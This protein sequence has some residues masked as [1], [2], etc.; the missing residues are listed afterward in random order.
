M[1][2]SI[3]KILDHFGL[4]KR[5]FSLAPDP[6]FLFM[7]AAHQRAKSALEYGLVARSPITLVTGEIGAGKTLLLRDFM[8]EI[9]EDVR[10]GLVANASPADRTEMLRL[11]LYALG[12]V[13]PEGDSY[14][15]LYDALEGF[16]VD[17]YREGRRVVLI[18]DEAQNLDWSSLEHLRMLTNINF[19]EHELVQL[20]L[21]GQSEL[22]DMIMRPDLRQ[23]AQRVSAS[24]H[25]PGLTRE[26]VG[27]YIAHRMALA[28]ADH[29]VFEEPTHDLI[30]DATQ[31]TTRLINQ[32]CDYA[33]LYAFAEGETVVNADA[34]NTVTG[35]GVLL[36]SH[37]AGMAAPSKAA[38]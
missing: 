12:R 32:L 28:G 6:A 34:V 21:I 17:E 35:D 38:E 37:S 25:L 16:L 18:F 1:S 11:I 7:S 13:P 10:I 15:T 2:F 14:A 23:L 3:D 19:A 20:M 29:P 9:E 27:A 4:T 31:G 24:V 26:D 5:P 22:R 36:V 33:L 30:F 8:N